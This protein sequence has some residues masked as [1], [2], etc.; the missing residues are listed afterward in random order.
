[1]AEYE[2][3]KVSVFLDWGIGAF[4]PRARS[5]TEIALMIDEHLDRG[6]ELVKRREKK[7]KRWGRYSKLVFKR[8]KARVSI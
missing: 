3:K 6:W 4:K 2:T 7:S 8:S 5:E 1:M